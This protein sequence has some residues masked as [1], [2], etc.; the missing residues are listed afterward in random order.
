MK[1]EG[2]RKRERLRLARGSRVLF[3]LKKKEKKNLCIYICIRMIKKIL[4]GV[5]RG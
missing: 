4:N 3:S 1:M 5:L 2:D